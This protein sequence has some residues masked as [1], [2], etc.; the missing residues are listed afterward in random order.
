MIHPDQ[1]EQSRP[2]GRSTLKALLS[3][4]ALPF[5]VATVQADERQPGTGDS[6]RS[7]PVAE[8]EQSGEMP[9][10]LAPVAILGSA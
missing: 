9:M 7:S 6:D 2:G 4:A 10:A 5:L 1:H 8:V 3:A